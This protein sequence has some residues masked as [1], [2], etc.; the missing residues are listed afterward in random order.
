M[1]QLKL[2]AIFV[3]ALLALTADAKS[4]AEKC[5]KALAQVPAE[6]DT[7]KSAY[8]DCRSSSVPAE[9]RAEATERWARILSQSDTA[10]SE[11]LY[12]ATIREIEKE[13]GADSAALLPLL[14][15][16]MDLVV[17]VS[18]GP[19]GETFRLANDI[20]RIKANVHG[21]RS[22]PAAR[23]LLVVGRLHELNGTMATAEGLYREAIGI[24]ETACAPKCDTL[25]V[26]YSMLRDL[27][28]TDPAR[29][30]EA[31]ELNALAEESGER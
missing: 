25:V 26:A 2:I 8:A 24:A 20:H 7:A 23:A 27:I 1:R 19:T 18:G 21:P 14:D 28:K 15:G 3:V 13:R 12:R 29:Q 30:A 6:R 5:Q 16:L 22:E 9:L 11:A 10:A 31:D 17:R 4:S